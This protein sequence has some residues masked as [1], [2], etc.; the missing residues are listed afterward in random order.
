MGKCSQRFE[1]R[2]ALSAARQT[3]LGVPSGASMYLTVPHYMRCHT[4][5]CATNMFNAFVGAAAGAR[6]WPPKPF[7][8][9]GQPKPEDDPANYEG[10]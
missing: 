9:H 4:D 7:T 6:Q 3:V 10:G 1:E 8:E 5:M 2:C